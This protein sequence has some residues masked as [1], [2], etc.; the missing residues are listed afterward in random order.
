MA[1]FDLSIYGRFRGV[2]RG[3][4]AEHWRLNTIADTLG[5]HHDTVC[6]VVESE[7]F[8]RSGTQVRPSALDPYKAFIT[9]PLERKS[10]PTESV[11]ISP[12]WGRS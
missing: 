4:Y 3:F 5:V 1:G 9:A 11:V 6:R 10:H 2:H 7:R 12:P 8:L